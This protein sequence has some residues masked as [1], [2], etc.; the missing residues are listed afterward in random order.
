MSYYHGSETPK[1]DQMVF[2]RGQQVDHFGIKSEI[3]VLVEKE[4]FRET[5]EDESII[6]WDSG[7]VFKELTAISDMG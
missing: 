1:L 6:G 5:G 3:A 7:P 2:M 4:G